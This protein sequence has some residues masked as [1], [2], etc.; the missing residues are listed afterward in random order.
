MN[1]KYIKNRIKLIFPDAYDIEIDKI[2]VNDNC[3]IFKVKS[4]RGML[5]GFYN[6]FTKN[7]MWC[8]Y[9]ELIDK[10]RASNGYLVCNIYDNESVKKF[11]KDVLYCKKHFIKTFEENMKLEYWHFSNTYKKFRL[12]QFEEK[13]MEIEGFRNKVNKFISKY[14]IKEFHYNSQQSINVYVDEDISDDV[15]EEMYEYSDEIDLC[16]NIFQESKI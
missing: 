10:F 13:F 5:F 4:I 7:N 1:R 14:N 6:Q 16:V 3:T 15:I 2:Y 8:Q 9:E 12:K 11:K